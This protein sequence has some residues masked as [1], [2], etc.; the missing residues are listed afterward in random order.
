MIKY[1]FNLLLEG[2]LMDQLVIERP[3]ISYED[4]E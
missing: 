1:S 3:V 2:K 4:E